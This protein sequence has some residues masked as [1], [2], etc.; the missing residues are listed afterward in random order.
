MERDL[1]PQRRKKLFRSQSVGLVGW[2]VVFFHAVDSFMLEKLVSLAQSHGITL[3][4]TIQTGS[5]WFPINVFI[6]CESP[7]IK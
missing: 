3:F 6:L 5:F 1:S 4:I 7:G 2:E